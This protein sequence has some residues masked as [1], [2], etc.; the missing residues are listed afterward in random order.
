MNIG[1]KVREFV[2]FG[3][4]MP[5]VYTGRVVW[6]H[7]RRIFYVVEFALGERGETVRESYF[8]RKLPGKPI[9][10]MRACR[11]VAQGPA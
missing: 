8:F 2:S 11:D 6:I 7:P 10:R 9:K 1:D 5:S 3:D 4:T